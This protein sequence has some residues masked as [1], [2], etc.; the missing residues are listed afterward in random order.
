MT[1]AIGEMRAVANGNRFDSR[2]ARQLPLTDDDSPRLAV[3]TVA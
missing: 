3:Q 1:Q 2:N